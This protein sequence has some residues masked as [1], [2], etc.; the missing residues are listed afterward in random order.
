MLSAADLSSGG[1][2]LGTVLAGILVDSLGNKGVARMSAI[3]QT[4]GI[5]VT[6]LG[7]AL[8]GGSQAHFN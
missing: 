2:G 4:N 7:A 8:S 6:D 3:M 5:V 1:G